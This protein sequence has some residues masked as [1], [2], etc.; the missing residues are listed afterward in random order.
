MEE[1][2][3]RDRM[4]RN[5]NIKII[6]R[7][8]ALLGLPFDSVLALTEIEQFQR[9]NTNTEETNSTEELIHLGKKF[10]VPI[11]QKKAG[12]DEIL[13]TVSASSP[14]AVYTESMGWVII[15]FTFGPFVRVNPIS[16]GSTGWILKS[17]LKKM[18]DSNNSAGIFDWILLDKGFESFAKDQHSHSGYR[19]SLRDIIRLEKQDI[20]AIAVYSVAVGIFSLII[21][22]GIQSLVNILNFG[23]ILQPVIVL[24]LLVITAFGIVGLMN[25]LQS[26]IA[27]L[28]QQR[29]FTRL[30]SKLTSLIPR[31]QY[32][33][34]KKYSGT[35]L[36]NYFL[37]IAII[38]KSVTFL[39]TNGLGIFLQ[40]IIGLLVLVLYHPIFIIFNIIIIT[41]VIGVI[42]YLIGPTG[43]DT[44]VKES[45]NKHKL[46]SWFEEM[47]QHSSV[48]RSGK[49]HFYANLRTENLVRNYIQSRKKHFNALIKQM[50]GFVSVQALGSGLLLSIGGWLV[51]QGQITLGQFVASEI[52]VTKILDNIAKLAKYLEAYYDLCAS[53]EKVNHLLDFPEESIG[54][55]S[56][57]FPAD[58]PVSVQIKSLPLPK[59][60]LVIDLQVNKGDIIV[61]A[62]ESKNH[63]S[64]LFD[65]IFGLSPIT[66]GGIEINSYHLQD[67]S[68]YEWRNHV[69]LLR[70]LEIFSGTIADNIKLNRLESDSSEIRSLLDKIGLGGKI[71]NLQGGIYAEIARNGYPFTRE[72][73]T[74][75]LFARA[76]NSRTGLVLIENVLDYLGKKAVEKILPLILENKKYS[77]FIIFS[78]RP[79]IKDIADR[80][81]IVKEGTI[82]QEGKTR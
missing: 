41:V 70:D 58:T 82:I 1:K 31:S 5:N 11:L 3:N 37:D 56:I 2:R 4:N 53:L 79:E 29:L 47:S 77:S 67:I 60:N 50:I 28:I 25:V 39:L 62:D 49:S 30:S 33:K 12:L 59:G 69:T 20:W 8:T 16:G 9:K 54:K 27:E 35:E 80:V 65:S 6:E 46:A 17:R 23:T 42:F 78:D 21:P 15:T 51:V 72:E 52:I 36:P 71:Q 7:F 43:I 61:I 22:I 57:D 68:L 38:Q 18:T 14:A 81:Y 32:T 13:S 19:D 48:F 24:T 76:F 64:D 74:Q 10:N 45:A 75:V 55:D 66:K 34:F 26:I 44:A 40:T 73:L 63:S